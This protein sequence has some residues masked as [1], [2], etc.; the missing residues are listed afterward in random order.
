MVVIGNFKH[1]NTHYVIFVLLDEP[2]STKGTFGFSSAGWNAV[3]TAKEII[4]IITE[5]NK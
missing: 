2:K 5:E 4:N 1:K 3:P